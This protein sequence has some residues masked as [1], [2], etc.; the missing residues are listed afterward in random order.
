MFLFDA[1]APPIVESAQ[2]SFLWLFLPV[3]YLVT[4]LIE[5]PVLIFGLSPKLTLKQ[6]LLCGIWLTACTYPIVVLVLPTLMLEYLDTSRALYL[7]VAETFAPAGEC[8]FF[9]LA[10]RGKGLLEKGDWFRCFGAIIIANL[11]SFGLGEVLNYY[12]WF[13]LFG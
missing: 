10:F 12:H 13:G 7:A 1:I 11:A 2:T 9:W 8:L 3:G 6:K 5:T 4:I